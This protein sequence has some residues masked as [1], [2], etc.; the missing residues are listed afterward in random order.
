MELS[1]VEFSRARQVLLVAI[2]ALSA[3]ACSS[4]PDWAN[5]DTWGE[6]SESGTSVSDTSSTTDQASQG[7]TVAEAGDKYPVLAD[8]PD[9]APPTT[10]TD[11]QKQVANALVGDRTQAQY[12]AEQL[13][14]GAESAAA[15][16][17]ASAEI[18]A[19]AATVDNSNTGVSG[20]ESDSGST[21]TAAIQSAAAAPVPSGAAAPRVASTQTSVPV[22]RVPPGAAPASAVSEDTALGF[23]PSHAPPLDPSVA[24]MVEANSRSHSA[25]ATV[26][27]TAALAPGASYGTPAATVIL[28]N[29]AL[30]A[31]GVA[32]IQAAVS[33]FRA[34][35]GQ[36][37]VRVVG[38]ADSAPSSARAL[39]RAQAGATA[40]AR[41]LIRLG[42]PAK[43]VLIEASGTA[44]GGQ[45]RADIFL[46]S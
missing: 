36:G 42:V 23:Q 4:L 43:R 8:T 14:A 26:R 9:K 11:E 31:N 22:K 40:V 34:K 38:H 20:P 2:F 12:S 17:P 15:P 25:I 21:A 33:A 3:S 37:F 10:S 13:R 5:P 27:P 45:Q 28:G 29:G 7:T 1:M 24:Q 18:G 46:Q 30:D 19:T 39:E 16:P 35:G 6:S 32:H 41:E 44:D